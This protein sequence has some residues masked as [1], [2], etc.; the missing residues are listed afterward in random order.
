MFNS[1]ITT[2]KWKSLIPFFFFL[3]SSIIFPLTV[4]GLVKDDDGIPITN[5][6]IYSEKRGTVSDQDGKFKI[7]IHNDSMIIFSHIGYQEIQFKGSDILEIIIMKKSNLLGENIYVNSSLNKNDLYNTPSS[8]TLF[9]SKELSIKSDNHFE[10]LIGQI[11]NL[12]Y[13]GGT[14]RPRYFQIRGIGERSHY[15]GEGPPNYSVGFLMDGF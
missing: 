10:S 15:A 2:A 7:E 6:N 12:N 5:V 8:V 3:F 4:S 1:Y 9:H 13:S 14:S 11:S